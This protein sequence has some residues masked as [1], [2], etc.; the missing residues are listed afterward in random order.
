MSYDFYYKELPA[1]GTRIVHLGEGG[2]E[3][4]IV[5]VWKRHSDGK[6]YMLSGQGCSCS[7]ISEEAY[8]WSDMRPVSDWNQVR[9]EIENVL[10]DYYRP[11]PA[12]TIN[13]LHAVTD[14]L[15][16]ETT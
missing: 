15:K 5:E 12:E 6:L 13:A 10:G 11:R 16:G 4:A 9:Q 1:E 2:Y 7:S 3:W 8:R 14:A